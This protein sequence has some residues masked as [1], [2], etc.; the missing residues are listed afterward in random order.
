MA[1]RYLII[2]DDNYHLKRAS[3]PDAL[4]L[5]RLQVKGLRRSLQGVTF[6]ASLKDSDSNNFVR[7][8]LSDVSANKA[9]LLLHSL[10]LLLG[11][12]LLHSLYLLLGRFRSCLDTTLSLL[13][14]HLCLATRYIYACCW[15]DLS[16]SIISTYLYMCVC[17]RFVDACPLCVSEL[18]Y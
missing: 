10:Y 18:T 14:G 13:S 16:Q 15:E 12:F 11:R 2:N 8:S 1:D 4:L 17:A 9:V 6:V 3:N 5:F 7:L